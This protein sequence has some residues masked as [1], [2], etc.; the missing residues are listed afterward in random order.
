M[1]SKTGRSKVIS[2]PVKQKVLVLLAGGFSLGLTRS[3]RR[4]QY[5]FRQM[6]KEWREINRRYLYRIIKEF[7]EDHLVDY[8]ELAD[9]TINLVITEAGK[10]QAIR[11]NIDV[12]EIKKPRH[13]DGQWRAVLFDIPEKKRRARDTLR[14][15]LRDLGFFEFLD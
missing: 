15:K 12:M 2:S 8:R 5:I 9:G 1:K 3:F 14:D 13:W 4:Q 10:L 7:R 6:K 11:F